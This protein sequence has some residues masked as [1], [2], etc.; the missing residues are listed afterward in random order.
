RTFRAD[1]HLPKPVRDEHLEG[2]LPCMATTAD[3]RTSVLH[4]KDG[5]LMTPRRVRFSADPRTKDSF[6]KRYDAKPGELTLR[7]DEDVLDASTRWFEHAKKVLVK[8]G[9]HLP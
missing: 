4:L 7:P 5:S 8:D 3:M 9:Y 6:L 1:S 2:R